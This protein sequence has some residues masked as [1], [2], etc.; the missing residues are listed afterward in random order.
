[1]HRT[2]GDNFHKIVDECFI[3]SISFGFIIF[4]QPNSS[5]EE[6]A[7][8]YRD[9]GIRAQRIKALYFNQPLSDHILDTG[10]GSGICI[11]YLF[12]ISCSQVVLHCEGEQINQIIS[13]AIKQ[14]SP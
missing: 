13:M 8:V 11:Q 9:R 10:A 4:E 2:D 12:D 5:W 7:I 14:M 3:F 1:M 6:T